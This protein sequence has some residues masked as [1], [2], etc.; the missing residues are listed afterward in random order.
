MTAAERKDFSVD[1][2][3][4][5]SGFNIKRVSYRHDV[6]QGNV[7]FAALHPAYV[8]SVHVGQLC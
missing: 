4:E 8:V 6:Q 3:E 2:F 7:P 1:G 5:L